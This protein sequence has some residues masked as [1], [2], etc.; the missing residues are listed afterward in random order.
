[1]DFGCFGK[2]RKPAV[3]VHAMMII[4]CSMCVSS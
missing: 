3:N 1:M 4:Y 2:P